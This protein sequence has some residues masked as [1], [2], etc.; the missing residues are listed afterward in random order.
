[1][2]KNLVYLLQ[3][4]F[5]FGLVTSAY[6]LLANEVV[7]PSDKKVALDVA[8][9]YEQVQFLDYIDEDDIKVH[10]GDNEKKKYLFAPETLE[11]NVGHNRPLVEMKQTFSPYTLLIEDDAKFK[12]I[13]EAYVKYIK[14]KTKKTLRFVFSNEFRLSMRFRDERYLDQNLPDRNRSSGMEHFYWQGTNSFHRVRFDGVDFHHVKFV[15]GKFVNSSFRCAKLADLDTSGIE[16]I[17]CDFTDAVIHDDMNDDILKSKSSGIC[18]VKDIKSTRSYKEKN[19]AGV[20]IRHWRTESCNYNYTEKYQLGKPSFYLSVEEEK[21]INNAILSDED[22]TLDL[23]G[24]NLTNLRIFDRVDKCT[25]TDAQIYGSQLGPVDIDKYTRQNAKIKVSWLPLGMSKG[26][27]YS[28][29]DYKIGSVNNV[30]FRYSEFAEADFRLINFTGCRFINS[31]V[32]NAD[33]T[34]AIISRCDFFDVKNLTLGQ[35]KSTW[36]YKINRMTGI[37]L[38]EEIQKALDAEKQQARKNVDILF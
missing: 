37:K 8:T 25:F 17:N 33:F 10:D 2:F 15:D 7:Q 34:G 16:Y 9:V 4:G 30:S 24:F 12:V 31:N 28:T 29:H 27:L 32:S 18:S 11:G 35:I 23:T 13:D 26:Q 1:M 6:L 14:E 38:P 22:V 5:C 21:K 3:A 19:L 20:C 36:N